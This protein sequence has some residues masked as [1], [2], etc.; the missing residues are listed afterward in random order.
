M[1]ASIAISLFFLKPFNLFYFCLLLNFND[2][3]KYDCSCR[4]GPSIINI[5]VFVLDLAAIGKSMVKKT[6]ILAAV[7]CQHQLKYLLLFL[8]K[9]CN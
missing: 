3:K 5:F 7:E 8:L 2:S 1:S 9:F 4:M 6:T